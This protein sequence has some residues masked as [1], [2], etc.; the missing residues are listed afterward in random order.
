MSVNHCTKEEATSKGYRWYFQIYYFD[1]NGKSR[2]YHSKKYATRKEA[3]VAE[4]KRL[5]KMRKKEINIT[6]MT[7]MELY[8]E[9]Y[10]YK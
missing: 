3:Q 7:F 4:A 9:F 8:E 2:K 5:H 1:E 10:E 6:D